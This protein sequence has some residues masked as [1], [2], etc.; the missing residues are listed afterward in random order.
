MK[1]YRVTPDRKSLMGA[2]QQIRWQGKGVSQSR[3]INWRGWLIVLGVLCLLGVPGGADS[4]GPPKPQGPFQICPRNA[5]DTNAYA[6]CA[7]AQC[8]LLN[9]VA[10]CKCDLMNGS[11][12]SS[13]FEFQENGTPQNV[14]DLLDDGVNNGFTVSTYSVPAQLLFSYA[15]TYNGSGPPPLA[16]YTCPGGSSGPYAQCDGGVCFNSTTG[17]DFPGV[18]PIGAT[19]VVCACPIT[20]PRREARLGFQIAGPW[21]KTDGSACKGTDSPDD[22]CS[23]DWFSQFCFPPERNPATG[24][25]LL[26]GAP[27]G[28]GIL[29]SVLLDGPPAP[30]VNQCQLEKGKKPKSK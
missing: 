11:S 23:S 17:K 1:T 4:A 10:Y 13:S 8:F 27:Q 29:L 19:Q 28:T 26:V 2:L 24:D 14:C 21:Q 22:C 7:T 5:S 20:D 3:G 25:T 16:L 18:G 9:D 30:Q 15:Q 6:L 12:I